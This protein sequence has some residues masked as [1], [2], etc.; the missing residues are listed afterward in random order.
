[1]YA[2]VAMSATVSVLLLFLAY[3]LKDSIVLSALCLF[4]AAVMTWI[5]MREEHG[6][7]F[8]IISFVIAS[9]VSVLITG[10]SVWSLLYALLFGHFGIIRFYVD[11]RLSD[12]L[13]RMLTKLLYCNAFTALGIGIAQFAFGTDLMTFYPGFP[14]W[15]IILVLEVAFV[16]FD[17]LYCLSCTLFDTHI[18]KFI[19][20]RR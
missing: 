15:A 8:A 19:L 1:M 17:R 5:P 4:F 16:I 3:V 18:R 14:I 2:S 20:P 6:G 12:K 10:A 9:V 7:A 11:T 13:M